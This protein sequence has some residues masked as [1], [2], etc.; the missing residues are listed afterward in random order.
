MANP[1]RRTSRARRGN[2]RSHLG[3]D[4]IQLVKCSHCGAALKPHTICAACGYYR[5]RQVTL[6]AND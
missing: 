6:A 3:L 2:R 4:R 1:K 5:G